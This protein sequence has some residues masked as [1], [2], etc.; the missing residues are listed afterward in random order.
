[1]SVRWQNLIPILPLLALVACAFEASHDGMTARPLDLIAVGDTPY[2]PNKNADFEALFEVIGT[3]PRDVI[4]HVGDIKR[5]GTPCTDLILKGQRAFLEM[6]AGA[7]VLTPGDNEWTDCHLDYTGGYDPRE[8]LS[9]VRK[10]FYPD[11][12]SLGAQPL[13]L[14]QQSALDGQFSDFVENARWRQN[15]VRF[16]TAHVVGSNNGLNRSDP[17]AVLEYEAR[18][19]ASTNWI[20]EGF[21][22]AGAEHAYAVVLAIHA[23]IFKRDVSEDGFRDTHAAI[24]EGASAFGGPVLV[25]H[26]DGHE[27]TLDKPFRGADGQSLENVVRLEVPGAADVRAVRV[28]IDPDAA[29]TFTFE[30]FGPGKGSN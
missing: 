5:G 28:R 13:V 27:Y 18:N 12:R 25:M 19:T 29:Q 4:I 16:V 22:L 7:L 9:L 8:R 10:L 14:E 24:T 17:V 26:G 2:H 1:M 6:V 15:G 21:A 20:R 30:P 3:T 23:D 11:N